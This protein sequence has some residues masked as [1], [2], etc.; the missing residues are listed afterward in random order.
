MF[1]AVRRCLLP[2]QTL[3]TT[4]TTTT[5]NFQ[6]KFPEPQPPRK[7]KV[8]NPPPPPQPPR[9]TEFVYTI[10][11]E[12]LQQVGLLYSRE[13]IEAFFDDH[14]V[15]PSAVHCSVHLSTTLFV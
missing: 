12:R 5:R 9:M 11:P 3:T 10:S 1:G 4:T 2:L 6:Y 7:V 8:S 13:W 15:G 14:F